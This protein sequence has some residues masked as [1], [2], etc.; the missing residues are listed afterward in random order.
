[1]SLTTMSTEL[2]NYTRRTWL[3]GGEGDNTHTQLYVLDTVGRDEEQRN[4]IITLTHTHTHQDNTSLGRTTSVD[5]VPMHKDI[6]LIEFIRIV[7]IEAG[8]MRSKTL[9]SIHETCT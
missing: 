3:V 9:Q 1:M 5:L 8:S 4:V 7:L 6:S 2:I